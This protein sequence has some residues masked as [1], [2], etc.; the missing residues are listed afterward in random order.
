MR[1][2]VTSGRLFFTDVRLSYQILAPWIFKQNAP[3][4]YVFKPKM[5]SGSANREP[6]VTSD[7]RDLFTDDVRDF[8]TDVWLSGQVLDPWIFKQSAPDL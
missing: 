5:G 4:M 7:V 6:P 1:P 8:F 3:D 2:L